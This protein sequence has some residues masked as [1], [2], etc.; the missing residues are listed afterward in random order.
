MW[1][2]NMKT[3]KNLHLAVCLI[4]T[5]NEP[6]E[7]D[8][9]N[10]VSTTNYELCMNTFLSHLNNWKYENGVKLIYCKFNIVKT[11]SPEN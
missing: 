1:N 9:R 6:V 5:I 8:I 11:C 7:T 4:V 10:S 2:E 3:Q